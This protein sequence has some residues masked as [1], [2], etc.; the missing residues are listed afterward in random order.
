VDLKMTSMSL[1]GRVAVVTG[2]GRGI[3]RA[4]TLALA[5]SGADQLCRMVLPSMRTRARGDVV[6]ISSVVTALLSRGSAPYAMA[7]AALRFLVSDA[8]GHVTG[9][10][11][12]VDGGGGWRTGIS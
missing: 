9:Q 4:I 11:I 10:R 1:Q 8:A 7:K 12:T 5:A 2:G 3:G 6:M